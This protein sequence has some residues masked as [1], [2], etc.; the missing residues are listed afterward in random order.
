M[1]ANTQYEAGRTA[2]RPRLRCPHKLCG[3]YA[4]SDW[5]G[6][7]R[8]RGAAKGPKD[9]PS[10]GIIWTCWS[11][12]ARARRTPAVFRHPERGPLGASSWC[13][14]RYRPQTPD[15]PPVRPPNAYA[16]Q[17]FFWPHRDGR[18]RRQSE[19]LFKLPTQTSQ[20]E[21]DRGSAEGR[22]KRGTLHSHRRIGLLG[23][24]FA[25]S[26][27]QLFGEQRLGPTQ[28]RP[29]FQRAAPPSYWRTTGRTAIGRNTSR[30]WNAWC[31]TP[32]C[33]SF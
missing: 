28:V 29:A 9:S 2:E 14:L 27:S 7:P 23:Q 15:R 17:H 6:S 1:Q 30:S 33:T 10:G 4:C 8:R 22:S 20:P 5:Q 24:E 18:F 19:F 3:F 21:I 26:F 11:N 13:W 12:S 16:R 32:G 25:Q 31:R